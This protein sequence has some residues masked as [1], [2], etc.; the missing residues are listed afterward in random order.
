MC[1]RFTLT[2]DGEK[3][4]TA[5]GLPDAPFDYRP[6]YNI[7]PQQDVLVVGTGRDGR[8]AGLMRWGL[9]PSWA[10]NPNEGAR[11]IN[12]RSE[13]VAERSAFREAFERRR[14]LIPAD[15]FYE[16]RPAG[17]GKTPM[18]ITRRG[19]EPFA[20]AGLWERWTRLGQDPLYTFTILTTS[21]APSIASIHDRMP[22]M[23]RPDQYDLWLDENA[24]AAALQTL[25]QPFDDDD[26]HAYPVSTAVNKV[27]NDG[28]ECVVPVEVPAIA[29]QTS[30]F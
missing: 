15:G 19:E 3:I 17:S 24:D 6:R 16:W 12:A 22:V 27:E 25:L 21:P 14:C 1:G 5:Y 26:L 4:R 13:T 8:R 29:E 11:M 9:V 10:E 30:F 7:A 20:F 23:L 18:R 28:P 2:A